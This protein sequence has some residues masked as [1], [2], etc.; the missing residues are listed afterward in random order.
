MTPLFRWFL[1][2]ETRKPCAVRCVAFI[3]ICLGIKIT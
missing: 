2:Q 1:M 3:V